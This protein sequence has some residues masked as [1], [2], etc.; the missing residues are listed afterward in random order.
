MER[1]QSGWHVGIQAAKLQ[2]HADVFGSVNQEFNLIYNHQDQ[3]VQMPPN[4]ILLASCSACKVAMYS[5]EDHILSF[6]GHIE[7]DVRY[8]K[9]LLS[10]RR[11]IFGEEKYLKAYESLKTR[12]GDTQVIDWIL[13]F[14]SQD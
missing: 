14:L 2:Q 6:Q 8:A 11:D 4:S 12:P 3:V 9:D 7:F 13:K 10:M 1:A 5:I